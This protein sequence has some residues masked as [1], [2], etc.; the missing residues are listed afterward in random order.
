M[1]WASEADLEA[2]FMED[3]GTLGY[4]LHH[5]SEISPE[6]RNPMRTSF[7]ETFLLRVFFEA[8]KRLNPELPDTAIQEAAARVHDVV[9]AT[10]L[11]QENRRLHDLLVNGVALSYFADGEERNARVQLVDW[12][13]ENNDWRAINQVDVVGKNPRIPDVVLFLNGLPLVVVELKGTEGAYIDAAYRQIDTYKEDIPDLFRSTLLTVISDGFNARYGSLSAGLDRFMRWRTVDGETI[14]AEN[15]TLALQT[16]TQGLLTPETLLDMLRWFVVFED[17]GKGPIKKIAG[18]HQ[19]HAVR[20]AVET[21]MAARDTDGKGGVIWHTQ[22]SGKSLLMTFLAGRVMHHA[23]LE[24]PTLLVLTDRNDL[25]NQLFG[26]FGRCKDLLGEEPVQADSIVAL[27]ALLNREVGGIVF[28]T[29]QKFRPEKGDIFPELTSRSNVIVMV[30]EA[31]RTQYG[32]EAKLKKDTG[33]VQHGLAYQLRQALPNAVYVAFTGTPVDL[34]GAN[35]RSVFGEYIDVY[36]IAQAVEDGATVPIYYEARVAKIEMDDDLSSE[37]DEE[38]DEATETLEE[39]QAAAA[40][41][42]WSRVEALVGA[43]KRLD[44]VVEDILTHFDARIEA[45]DGKAMI[46]C[47]SRRICVEVYERIVAARP[48]WHSDTDD[49]G[50]VKVIMTGSAT[51]PAEFRPHV[52]SKTRQETIRNRAKDPDDPLKIVIVRDMWLTG[53]DA[54]CMHTLYVDKPM[55]GHGL[56]QAIARVNRVFRNK[57]AGLIVDYIGIAADLKNALAHY[58]QSDQQQTGISEAEAVAA[59]MDALDVARSQLHGFDYSTTLGGTPADRL[60]ILP[61]ALNHVLEK[62]RDEGEGAGAVKRFNDAV[63]GLVKAF[64]L[65]S[66]STQAK[67]STEEVAFFSAI[68]SG[69]EKV[70]AVGRVGHNGSPDF[71]IQQLVNRAVVSTEV[72]DILEACGFD[73]PDISVLSDAFMIEIQN[74]KH[75]NLAVE[76]LKKLL[77]GEITSRTR[78]NVVRNE[79]FSTRLEQAIA[80]YHNRSVDALQVLQELIEI[81][82]DLRD[83]PED[84]LSQEERAFYDALAQNNSAV[85]IMSN[86]ELRVIAA[87]LVDT[88]RKNSGT[89]WWRRDNVRAKMRVTVKKILQRHGFPPDLATDAVKTVLR[90]AEALATAIL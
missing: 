35:T 64:K 7:R 51:D 18:Y 58:S 9:F 34:V 47:I 55:K 32:F 13:N 46:V 79:E 4:S 77:N 86:Q 71:A 24:N 17:E 85:E 75:R 21:V 52:R 73:R 11:V 3:L 1:A 26:T 80:S 82:K 6:M 56:M 14:E 63:A 10:D 39:D 8:L 22:G 45:I 20:K 76:A 60:K 5:G 41:R 66:G 81:A 23:G 15:S 25:D 62:E 28:S 38:F 89:D 65:A 19:F 53:F 31:H 90:Q 40:A 50:T 37:L 87:E 30:D 43:E 70:G 69:L 33:E 48:D 29:I 78:T 67:S 72:V 61:A 59:F 74:M 36:D 68:R 44:T 88:V 54:P 83:E 49:S 27:K 84:G 57:P 2:V 16:L 12:T 42:K